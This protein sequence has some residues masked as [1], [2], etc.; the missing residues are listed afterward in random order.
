[1]AGGKRVACTALAGFD[2]FLDGNDDAAAF[3]RNVA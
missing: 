1:V 2:S 3:G